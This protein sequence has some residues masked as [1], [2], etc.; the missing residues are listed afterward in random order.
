MA[1][2]DRTTEQLLIQLDRLEELRE[3]LLELGITSLAELDERIAEL[4]QQVGEDPDGGS[5][6]SV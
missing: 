2:R 1:A 6:G 3:D 5:D 4:E